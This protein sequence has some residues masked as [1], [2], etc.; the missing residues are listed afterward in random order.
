VLLL[1]LTALAVSPHDMPPTDLADALLSPAV[2]N[3]AW[4]EILRRQRYLDPKSDY[5]LKAETCRP[6]NHVVRDAHGLRAVFLTD[7]FADRETGPGIARGHFELVTSDAQIVEP[8][9][10]ANV[11]DGQGAV[12]DYNGAGDLALVLVYGVGNRDEPKQYVLHVV[13]LHKEQHSVLSLVLGPAQK[14]RRCYTRKGAPTGDSSPEC[15][16]GVCAV[17]QQSTDACD[18]LADWRWVLKPGKKPHIEIGPRAEKPAAA[19]EWSPGGLYLPVT[20]APGGFA[21]IDAHA[22]SKPPEVDAPDAGAAPSFEWVE[23]PVDGG[24]CIADVVHGGAGC[25]MHENID[26]LDNGDIAE[27]RGPPRLLACGGKAT[28]CGAPYV[29]QCGK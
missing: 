18:T 5:H 2:R 9:Q 7:I 12:I 16:R 13:P 6:V 17:T 8:F 29:C 11:L 27:H 22:S 4:C 20:K 25:S 10:R 24:T 23:V 28:V 26:L 21:V 1:V 15:V 14:E 3:A 19:F